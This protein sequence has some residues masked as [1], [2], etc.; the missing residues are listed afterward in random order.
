[1]EIL[2]ALRRRSSPQ[3]A[4]K[5]G[6]W[7]IKMPKRFASNNLLYFYVLNN[8]KFILLSIKIFKLKK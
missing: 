8:F 1:M 5:A 3:I 4:M 6:K 2:R 7:L